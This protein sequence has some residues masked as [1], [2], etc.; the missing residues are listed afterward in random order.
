MKYK[1]ITQSKPDLLIG[2]KE[3]KI[4]QIVDFVIPP[5]YNS[6]KLKE[7]E[8]LEK[9]LDFFRGVKNT[10]TGTPHIYPSF[11]FNFQNSLQILFGYR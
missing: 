7:R 10:P 11:P 6:V 2:S 9:Y 4:C 3:K 8:K 5:D 1:R